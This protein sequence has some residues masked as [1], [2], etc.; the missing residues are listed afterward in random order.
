MK[1]LQGVAAAPGVVRG[2]W[3]LIDPTPAPAGGRIDPEA[4]SSEAER[5]S[6]ASNAAGDE[7]EAIAER[8]TADGHTDEAA[9]FLAQ[10]SIARDPALID[11]AVGRI[12]AVQRGCG[13]R[14]PGRGWLLR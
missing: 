9:I 4:A 5:L 2:A 3:V 11:L 7:L 13:R 6:A 14:D 12:N 10:S 1:R 8:I